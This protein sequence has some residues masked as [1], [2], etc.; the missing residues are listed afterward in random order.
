MFSFVVPSLLSAVVAVQSSTSVEAGPLRVSW[1][2]PQGC[3]QAADALARVQAL[4][5]SEVASVLRHAL[6]V[7]ALVTLLDSGRYQLELE[8]REG[9][10]A[11]AR[12]IDAA[13]CQEA[14][15]AGALV[16]ALTIDPQLFQRQ[17]SEQRAA[18]EPP[19]QPAPGASATPPTTRPARKVA[20]RAAASAPSSQ[21]SLGEPSDAPRGVDERWARWRQLSFGAG[22]AGLVDGGTLP[23]LGA[24]LELGMHGM[25]R[26]LRTEVS[27]IWLPSRRGLVV[28]NEAVGGS[29]QLLALVLREC[30]LGRGEAWIGGACVGL[31]LGRLHAV[32]FGADDNRS[33]DSTWLAPAFGVMGGYQ[34]ARGLLL[35]VRLELVVPLDRSE[36]IVVNAGSVHM[37]DAVVGRAG[38]GVDADFW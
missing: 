32:A 10:D 27:G 19:T 37:P 9:A 16:I 6:E 20:T 30:A 8:M 18:S 29:F 3:P 28:G 25:W 11:G 36:F 38:L 34:A 2:A 35:R 26:A 33:G 7:R 4:L 31:E 5:G 1:S 24:G 21:A 15:Q 17:D 14:A 12:T 13:T 22:V 23:G